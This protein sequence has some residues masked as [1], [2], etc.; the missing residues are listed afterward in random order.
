M[1]RTVVTLKPV[2]LPAAP[3]VR[4]VLP[5]PSRALFYSFNFATNAWE[6][7]YDSGTVATPPGVDVLSL[8]NQI[9]AAAP[10]GL[11]R[12]A[13]WCEWNGSQWTGNQE[14]PAGLVTA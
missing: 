13:W 14:P 9:V 4:V 8:V 11:G 7:F 2:P 1:T 5:G 3:P 12:Y 6:L 10:S